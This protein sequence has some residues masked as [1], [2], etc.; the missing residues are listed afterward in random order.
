MGSAPSK[1]DAPATL[2]EK[3]QTARSL[4][5][6]MSSLSLDH[7][8]P[9]SKDGALSLSNVDAWEEEISSK[10]KLQLVRTILNHS[11]VR[12]ALQSREAI[13]ADAHVFNTEVEFKTGPIT[14]QK[15]SGR[16]WLFATTNVLRYNV[17][18]RFN[19]EDFQL[20]QVSSMTVLA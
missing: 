20:S 8:T 9:T 1:P 10:P 13:I 18:K 7:K 12:T 19:L 3:Q 5:S 11:D 2:N 17:M 4:A 15:S 14:N 16:C 6:G